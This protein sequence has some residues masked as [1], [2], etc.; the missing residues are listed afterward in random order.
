GKHYR[1]VRGSS[2]VAQRERGGGCGGFAVLLAYASLRSTHDFAN[3]TSLFG[4][5]PHRLQGTWTPGPSG[6]DKLKPFDAGEAHGQDVGPEA[7]GQHPGAGTRDAVGIRSGDWR[8]YG[9]FVNEKLDR[10]SEERRV[11]K[12]VIAW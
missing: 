11:G 4:R 6:G 1:A 5:R 7:R 3:E 8:R 2:R 12:G 10:R 9:T